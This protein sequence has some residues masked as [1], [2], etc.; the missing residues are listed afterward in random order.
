MNT[1][2]IILG[3]LILLASAELFL[4]FAL[5]SFFGWILGIHL[6]CF[7][8]G[9][10]FMKSYPLTDLAEFSA[11]LRNREPLV[12]EYLDEVLI[13]YAII[14]LLVPGLICHV[15]GVLLLLPGFRGKYLTSAFFPEA[16]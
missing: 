13:R 5:G 11:S 6:I 14:L 2:K 4:I 9:L 12:K 1:Q 10:S 7:L 16:L 15:F 3:L 8:L